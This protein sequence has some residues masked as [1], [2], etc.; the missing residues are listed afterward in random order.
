MN[1]LITGGTGMVGTAL[2][3]EILNTY[4][5]AHIFI[6]TRSDK[7]NTANISYL[8]WSEDK[9]HQEIPQLDLVVNLAG[10]SLNERWTEDHKQKIIKSR[11]ES[12][13]KLLDLFKNQDNKPFF[14][15]ASAVGY[16]PPSESLTYDEQNTFNPFDFLSKTVYLWE[17]AASKIT[18]LDV[19][20][21]ICRF[22][23]IFSNQGGALPL[24]VKP[25]QLMV[26]GDIGDGKQPYSW[27][28]IEDLVKSIL[29][30]FEKRHTGTFNLTAPS[31]VT[32]SHLG[33]SIAQ[34]LNKPHWTV[35]PKKIMSLLLGEQA[36][37]ITK[38]QYVLPTHLLEEGY[39]FKYPEVDKALEDLYGE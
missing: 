15:S 39:T 36:I 13:E 5:N 16:Y 24:M 30:I 17:Q 19:P 1:I 12:T 7:K 34:V 37:M 8:N 21:A 14:V 26:G 3:K 9:W 28:H 2:T 6:P 11:V 25:Y 38:G 31:P 22:G 29:F 32:Q 35:V 4:Q 10:A 33:K 23:V 18:N 20:T 27:I